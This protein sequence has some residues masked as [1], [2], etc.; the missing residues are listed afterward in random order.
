M[1]TTDVHPWFLGS[2]KATH[3]TIEIEAV[4]HALAWLRTLE[5][6]DGAVL[7]ASDRTHALMACQSLKRFSANVQ[8]VHAN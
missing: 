8:L 1:V 7:I 2:A 6:L 3:N 5:H 4:G